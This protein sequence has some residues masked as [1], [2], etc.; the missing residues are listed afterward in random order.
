MNPQTISYPFNFFF[1]RIYPEKNEFLFISSQ[2][3]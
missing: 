2:N 3:I 1:A